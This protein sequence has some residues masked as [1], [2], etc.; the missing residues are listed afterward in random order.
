MPFS[1]YEIAS[2]WSQATRSN[3]E[4]LIRDAFQRPYTFSLQTQPVPDGNTALVTLDG[5][6]H[7]D[8]TPII[9]WVFSLLPYAGLSAILTKALGGFT[10]DSGQVSIK[11]RNDQNGYGTYNAYL[12]KPQPG[13]DYTIRNGVGSLYIVALTLT[14]RIVTSF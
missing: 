11:T 8:G 7:W 14:F 9:T 13:I 1:Q 2:G 10:S 5:A 3:V 6:T 12:A 4:D